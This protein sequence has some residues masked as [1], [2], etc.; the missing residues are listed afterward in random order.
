L[1]K[2][3]AE[4][5]VIDDI[6]VIIL[7]D[8]LTFRET[9]Q[10]HLYTAE[11]LMLFLIPADVHSLCHGADQHILVDEQEV[12][13]FCINMVFCNKIELKICKLSVICKKKCSFASRI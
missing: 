6:T 11:C 7:V 9:C 13:A 5:T 10:R 3:H 12:E 8:E 2:P 4:E 1:A